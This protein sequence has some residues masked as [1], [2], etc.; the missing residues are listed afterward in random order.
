MQALQS[1]WTKPNRTTGEDRSKGGF[2]S[3]R[4]NL[5]SWGLS[6]SLLQ[7][8]Y[9]N[10]RLITDTPGKKLLI[11]Q[12]ALP[13][14]DVDTRLDALNDY[15][16]ELWA[17]GKM[18]SYEIQ[19]EA[20]VH[21]DH[22]AYLWNRLPAYM[23]QAPVL[24]QSPEKLIPDA[25]EVFE[26]V[27]KR[28]NYFPAPFWARRQR[29]DLLDCF[30]AGLIGGQDVA[31]FSEYAR[32]AFR[33]VERNDF[34]RIPR[35]R[36]PTINMFFEQL[37]L[38]CFCKVAGVQVAFLFEQEY[39]YSLLSNHTYRNMRREQGYVH[40]MWYKKSPDMASW[41]DRWLLQANPEIYYRID[42]YCK[43]HLL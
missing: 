29:A 4:Y 18:R 10:T 23:E 11:D 13:Y 7:Q 14:T 31:L 21:I 27:I 9:G 2:Y 41:V 38:Q 36:W 35:K 1:F 8:V 43:Q 39:P 40:L 12:L 20:F 34:N 15:P 30:N 32:E 28:F 37:M 19:E 25:Q 42:W 3:M 33:F 22:D 16:Q 17:L 26:L 24:S 6:S 5:Q